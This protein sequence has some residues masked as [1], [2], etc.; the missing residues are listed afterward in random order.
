MDPS[1]YK[2][3]F[4]QILNI[5]DGTPRFWTS[6][7][8]P[9]GERINIFN[10]RDSYFSNI[11]KIKVT[12]AKESNLGKFH[13]DNTIT[14]LAQEKFDAGD[15]VTFVNITGT[16]DTNYLYSAMTT[17]DTAQ[18]ITG[19]SGET[20]NGSGATYIDVSYATTQTSNILTPVR[21][22]LPYGSTETNYKFPADFEYYQVITAITV[23]DAAKI[24]NTGT[25]QSFGNVINTPT[26]SSMWKRYFFINWIREQGYPNVVANPYSFFQNGNEQYILILQRGVDPYSPKYV[27]EYSLGTLFGTTEFDTN[28]TITASTRVNIPIQQLTSSQISVQPYDQSSMYYK[29]YFFKPGITGNNTAG[30]NFTGFTTTNTAYYGSL[31]ALTTPLPRLTTVL[32]TAAVNPGTVSGVKIVIRSTTPNNSDN[33]ENKKDDEVVM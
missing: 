28:W 19:I 24:W 33:E 1:R 2:L 10:Q 21:Y 20:Y 15:L 9:I 14:V 7:D 31:D 23:S 6:F 11:N 22:S 8:L 3:P 30:Y 16:T 17:G 27:N 13:Y 26:S 5:A 32:G 25:T 12:I 18:L 4:S 29:S